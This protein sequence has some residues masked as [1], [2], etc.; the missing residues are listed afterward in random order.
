MKTETEDFDFYFA[1]KDAGYFAQSVIER[2]LNNYKAIFEE[3]RDRQ[4]TDEE[5]DAFNEGFWNGLV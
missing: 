4:L 2:V 5:W 3:E 1:G